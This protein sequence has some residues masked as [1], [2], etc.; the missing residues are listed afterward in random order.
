VQ[1][2]AIAEAFLKE[3]LTLQEVAEWLGIS[4]KTVSRLI[5]SGQIPAAKVGGLYRLR[6]ADVEEYVEK[7]KVLPHAEDKSRSLAHYSSA[8]S[9]PLAATLE[10]SSCGRC[11]R[12]LRGLT[13]QA[14]KCQESSCNLP[15]CRICWSNEYDR[16]CRRHRL[17]QAQKLELANKKLE[18]REISV[19][20][21]A[22]EARK[23]EFT[24]IHRF[25]QRI[26]Q[27]PFLISPVDGVKYDVQ[28]WEAIHSQESELD[29]SRLSSL[30]LIQ[31][32][33]DPQCMPLNITSLYSWPPPHLRIRH[34]KS[35]FI[36]AASVVTDLTE[37]AINGFSTA[38]TSRS[39]LLKILEE[40]AATARAAEAFCVLGLAS[41]AGWA[42]EAREM[43][44]GGP[45]SPSFSSLYLTVCLV[46]LENGTLAYNPL[47]RRLR[48]YLPVYRG[49][50]DEELIVRVASWVRDELFSGKTS[51]SLTE[52]A[53]GTNMDKAIVKE[54]FLLLE[55]EGGFILD[56]VPEF[57]LTVSRRI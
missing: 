55:S 42:K 38:P 31:P 49:E 30:R 57:G 16:Y 4:D 5:L 2:I 47:D 56:N 26:R 32:D 36:I 23:R 25:D 39:R 10:G 54:A 43:V 40:R 48:P 24:F 15:L 41:P 6:L 14:G 21:T 52:A 13:G 33:M 18:S 9:A 1:Q 35:R 34:T 17:S 20:V 27:K 37:M 45:R 46:D 29:Q 7:Q 22:E 8:G 51:L 53:A 19:L 12:L 3:F 11:Q 44:E 28:S 50:L